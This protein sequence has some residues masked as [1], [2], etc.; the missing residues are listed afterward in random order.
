MKVVIAGANAAKLVIYPI[1]PGPMSGGNL[2]NWVICVLTDKR[3]RARAKERGV[4]R[5]GLSAFVSGAVRAHVRRRYE[6]GSDPH[7]IR[8]RSRLL[9]SLAAPWQRSDDQRACSAAGRNQ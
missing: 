4:A 9:P 6:E 1:A 5:E 3:A 2:P 8:P 7:E